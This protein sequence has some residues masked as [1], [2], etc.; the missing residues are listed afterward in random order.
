ME[1]EELR[2]TLTSICQKLGLHVQIDPSEYTIQGPAAIDVEHDEEGNLVGIGVYDGHRALY[3]TSVDMSLSSILCS[4]DLVAHN[5]ISDFDL[6]RQWGIPVSD[7]QLIWD[8]MLIGHIIDSSLRTYGL[9][10]MAKRELGIEY[11]SYSDICGK[12]KAKVR[13]TLDKWPV[14]IGSMYNAADG[15]VTKKIQVKQETQV[16]PGALKL[17]H[18]LEKPVSH[19]FASMETRGIRVDL[20]Y[21]RDLKDKLE[22]QKQPIEAE[23]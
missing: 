3:F 14:D 20:P 13:R 10:D 5:G 16:Y 11:P 9:K 19:V 21:L 1:E 4:R 2:S 6:L 15:F 18:E 17:F 8:T 23:I 22:A 7:E 12:E